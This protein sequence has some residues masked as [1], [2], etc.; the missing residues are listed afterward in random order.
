MKITKIA[1][2]PRRQINISEWNE[3]AKAYLKPMTAMERL[4]YNDLINTYFN[5]KK[6]DIERTEAIFQAAMICLVDEDGKPL[7]EA[8]QM[9]DLKK[10]CFD[11][12]NRM[13]TM[14]YDSN[15]ADETLTKN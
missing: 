6:K 5:E 11:P 3:T 15:L 7:L 12:I 1:D 9:E 2:R 14:N 10:A 4:T 13:I 8:D